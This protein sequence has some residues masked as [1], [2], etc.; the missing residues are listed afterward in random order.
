MPSSRHIEDT[1]SILKVSGRKR[2]IP[3]VAVIPGIAPKIIPT[4]VPIS[5]SIKGKGAKT[6]TI[7]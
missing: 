3:I 4:N 2:T 7:P 5:R 6:L 1:G